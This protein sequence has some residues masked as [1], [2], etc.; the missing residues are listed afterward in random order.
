MD[1]YAYP[2]GRWIKTAIVVA[3][4]IIILLSAISSYNS[5]V[6]AEQDVDS[7]WSQVENVMQRRADTLQNLVKAVKAYTKHEEKVFSEIASA[8][9]VLASAQADI[10]SKLEAGRK[11]DD[12]FRQVLA[13]VENYPELKSSEQY[14]KLQD[15][16]EGSEN[17][18]TVARMDFINAVKRY[19]TMVKKFP[20]NIFA[21]FMGFESKDYFKA[22]PDAAKS[23]DLN[24]DWLDILFLKKEA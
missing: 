20:N 23:P 6:K 5:L 1:Y 16:I 13:I 4:S 3:I 21:K 7:T 11:I 15:Q 14:L 8:R 24:F 17:R 10:N 2:Y 12:S 22:D 18:V 19:N 9:S